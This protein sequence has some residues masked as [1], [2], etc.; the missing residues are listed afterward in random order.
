MK[1]THSTLI[2]F[3]MM[4]VAGLLFAIP[5]ANATSAQIFE[6]NGKKTIKIGTLLLDPLHHNNLKAMELAQDDFNRANTEYELKLVPYALR[7]DLGPHVDS[8]A[9]TAMNMAF[10]QDHVTYFVGPMDSTDVRSVKAQL[11]TVLVPANPDADFLVISPASTDPELRIND[12]VFR[13]VV[14]DTH[15]TRA[16]ANLISSEGKTHVIMIGL[17]NSQHTGERNAWS[18]GI[19]DGF[20]DNFDGS[21]SEHITMVHA[22]KDQS[23][24]SMAIQLDAKVSEL[25]N[26]HKSRNVAIVTAIYASDMLRLVQA[27]NR[28]VP[29]GSLESVKW[30]GPDAIAY[31]TNVINDRDVG[32]FLAQVQF[33]ASQYAGDLDN[34]TRYDVESRLYSEKGITQ[35]DSV[36][37][38]TSYDA[39]MLLANAIAERDRVGGSSDSAKSVKTH[40]HDLA[41]DP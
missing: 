37:L 33:T 41:D 40:L 16:L 29:S 21:I 17:N 12:N 3:T 10:L 7:G 34:P 26:L 39:V 19:E 9:A 22:G 4:V 11:D 20:T 14:D 24:H 18:K 27:I 32:A 1:N 28:H 2:V 36:Y 15:Q 6:S 8:R 25:V 35:T 13:M 30:Y 38:Y 23:Y 5:H 31:R